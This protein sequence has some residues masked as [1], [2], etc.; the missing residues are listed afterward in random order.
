ML[1]LFSSYL[2]LCYTCNLFCVFILYL[3]TSINSLIDSN[4][5][6]FGFFIYILIS[7]LQSIYILLPFLVLLHWK[8]PRTLL[9]GNGNRA[10]F[11]LLRY[12][13]FRK[14]ISNIKHDVCYT[15]L[16][17]N[18]H[19]HI[20]IHSV[21]FSKEFVVTL[22]CFHHKWLQCFYLPFLHLLTLLHASFL[23]YKEFV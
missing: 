18:S 15:F 20:K 14:K 19:Y 11:C 23:K 9:N 1:N 7:P 13:Y 6:S 4:S 8:T 17:R 10:L 5:S 12:I 21:Y 2:L 22:F 16:W 3:L